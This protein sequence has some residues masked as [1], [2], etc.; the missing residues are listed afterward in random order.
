MLLLPFLTLM[1]LYPNGWF[2]T[3]RRQDIG[4]AAQTCN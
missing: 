4:L 3:E 1:N 2:S